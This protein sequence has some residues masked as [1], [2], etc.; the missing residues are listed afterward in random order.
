[1]NISNGAG[2]E[3]K[4]RDGLSERE[5]VVDELY[6]LF[7]NTLV[8]DCYVLCVTTAVVHWSSF[9]FTLSEIFAPPT[10]EVKGVF[11]KAGSK[12]FEKAANSFA[13][14]KPDTHGIFPDN[15]TMEE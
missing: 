5:G 1:M 13:K 6:I 10:M 15:P 3:R 14:S 8:T 12:T 11:F 7:L 9:V 4:N 2:N